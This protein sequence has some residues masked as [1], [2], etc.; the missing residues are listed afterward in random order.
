MKIIE[1]ILI[2]FGK[3]LGLMGKRLIALRKLQR[4]GWITLETSTNIKKGS[5]L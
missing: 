1:K 4:H 5:F 2:P 3:F